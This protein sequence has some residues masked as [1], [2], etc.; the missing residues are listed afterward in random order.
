MNIRVDLNYPI[1]DG[2]EV[3][4]RSPV[5]CSQVTGLKLYH[6]GADGNT[7]SQEF[8]F[9]DAHGNN[10][11]DIDHLF[12][13]NVVV[14]V[15]LDVTN[16]M[17]FVQNADTNAYLEKQFSDVVRYSE[18]DFDETKQKQA[19]KNIGAIGNNLGGEGLTGIG[20]LHFGTGPSDSMDVRVYTD[21]N[22]DKHVKFIPLYGNVTLGGFAPGVDKKDVVTVEQLNNALADERPKEIYIAYDPSTGVVSSDLTYAD[23]LE[24]LADPVE[25]IAFLDISN[26]AHKATTQTIYRD[27]DRYVRFDFANLGIAELDSDGAW[28][29]IS[30]DDIVNDCV[31]EF[32]ATPQ[33]YGAMGDGVADDTAAIQECINKNKIIFFPLGTYKITSPL[34]IPYGRTIMGYNKYSTT[35]KCVGCDAVHF[36]ENAERGCFKSIGIRGDESD[37]KAFV[38]NKYVVCWTFDDIWVQRFGNTFFYANGVGHV[39]NIIIQNSELQW[40]GKNCV[41]FIYSAAAQ[42]NN[43]TIRN[44][45][46]NTFAEDGLCVTGNNITLMSNTIQNV[47][48]GVNIDGTLANGT[49]ANHTSKGIWLLT[50]YF[51]KIKK[52]FVNVNAHYES[53]MDCRVENICIIGNYGAM[54]SDADT[55]YPS[56][57]FSTNKIINAPHKADGGAMV[58][59]VF[60]AS[61][62]FGVNSSRVLIDG[63]GILH[64]D[65]AFYTGAVVGNIYREDGSQVFNTINMNNARV[66]SRYNEVTQEFR[67]YNNSFVPQ[68]AIVTAESVTLQPNTSL[69][70]FVEKRN[71]RN[72]R[73]SISGR[74]DNTSTYS[75]IGHLKNGEK[76]AVYS[77]ANLVNDELHVGSSGLSGGKAASD[78]V[79]YEV[80]INSKK[81]TLVVNNPTIKFYE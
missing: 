67:L 80:T 53:T 58:T 27:E 38:F 32:Y 39:N 4:F 72:I 41:E 30:N 56:I 8:A 19:R 25:I 47:Q 15:I 46:I 61:N 37:H 50:N 59:E 34:S 81:N 78:F 2:T 77:N 70:F 5:D 21:K 75:V 51:E 74:A 60:Y 31:K 20:M 23:A 55:T 33:M 71:V 76:V 10:V 11:G 69:C 1:K 73:I 13:E 49:N 52:S 22:N 12:A 28:S 35:I 14:K 6:I 45:D 9:A 66:F 17:A 40:G 29:F 43:I 79:G 63:G 16:S 7:A 68:D 54:A 65:S 18:Q 24:L 36:Q 3:V 48:F 64:S 42:I 62:R 57:K 44:C 26:G